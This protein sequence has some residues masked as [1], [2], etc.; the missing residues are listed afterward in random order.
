MNDVFSFHSSMSK[1]RTNL[2]DNKFIAK[3]PPSEFDRPLM[4][5]IMAIA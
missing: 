4:Y 2:I 3:T 1:P 5:K